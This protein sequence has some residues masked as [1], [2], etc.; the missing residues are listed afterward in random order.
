MNVRVKILS[1]EF[2]RPDRCYND[3]SLCGG[4]VIIAEI[5]MF[6]EEF[7]SFN[8]TGAGTISVVKAFINKD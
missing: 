6:L 1:F 5:P 7:F 2:D 8:R 4:L 3:K